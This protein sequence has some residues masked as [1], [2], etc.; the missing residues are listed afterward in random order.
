MGAL[1][2]AIQ[3]ARSESLVANAG[4]VAARLE[5]QVAAEHFGL[6]MDEAPTTE[7]PGGRGDQGAQHRQRHRTAAPGAT[8]TTPRCPMPSRNRSA[9]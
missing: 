1:E 6:L 9:V 8:A 2:Q 5:P 4:I 7:P 3:G